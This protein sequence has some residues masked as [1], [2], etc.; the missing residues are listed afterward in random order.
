MK[1]MIGIILFI[2]L[3]LGNVQSAKAQLGKLGKKVS[4]KAKTEERKLKKNVSNIEKT[5]KLPKVNKTDSSSEPLHTPTNT[6]PQQ[7]EIDV[8]AEDGCTGTDYYFN[9]A[10][11]D[12]SKIKESGNSEE[13]LSVFDMQNILNRVK[14]TYLKKIKARDPNCDTSKLEQEIAEA[15]KQLK[16]TKGGTTFLPEGTYTT[17]GVWENIIFGPI[18]HGRYSNEQ[19]IK[20]KGPL[21]NLEGSLKY[22]STESNP[23]FVGVEIKGLGAGVIVPQQNDSGN[24]EYYQLG[25]LQ[26]ETIMAM[27]FFSNTKDRNA[28]EKIIE[29]R[30]KE[31]A[32]RANLE[33]FIKNNL[34]KI[35]VSTEGPIYANGKKGGQIGANNIQLTDSFVLGQPVWVRIFVE[36]DRTPMEHLKLT[37][38]PPAG[39][40]GAGI[41]TRILFDGEEVGHDFLRAVKGDALKAVNEWKHYR[42]PFFVPNGPAQDAYREGIE[43][44]F[45]KNPS[46]GEHTLE[47][48]KWVV[49]SNVTDG[50]EFPLEI[51]MAT[52]GPL[53]VM[54]TEDSWKPFCNSGSNNYGATSGAVNNL[55]KSILA[56][57]QREATKST[58]KERPISAVH[59]KS[60]KIYHELTGKYMYTIHEGFVQSKM[61]N[62]ARL[63]QGFEIVDGNYHG[64]VHNTQHYLPPNCN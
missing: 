22:K 60:T 34:G 50:K 53:K 17:S 37:G 51:M 16:D 47:I 30:S 58:W 10:R 21:G 39:E 1:K 8:E 6:A 46:L 2:A 20:I 4:N 23:E 11:K 13:K 9:L 28:L 43:G 38:Y 45:S 33:P 19:Q 15:E 54:V 59:T 64:T 3:G 31:K 32:E 26:G 63:E 18:T 42:E 56:A 35:L 44:I 14:D 49:N 57:V 48:Q 41:R 55:S 40:I 29:Q 7:T 27:I 36:G 25:I 12:L 61:P 52:S 24:I 62:G 5:G